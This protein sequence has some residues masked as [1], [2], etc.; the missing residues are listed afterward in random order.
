MQ[1]IDQSLLF[2]GKSVADKKLEPFNQVCVLLKQYLNS[3]RDKS[4]NLDIKKEIEKNASLAACELIA[5][6]TEAAKQCPSDGRGSAEEDPIYR[7]LNNLVDNM[8][9]LL[10]SIASANKSLKGEIVIRPT[11]Q[12]VAL[13]NHAL[14]CNYIHQFNFSH[15]VISNCIFNAHMADAE[16]DDAIIA[17]CTFGEDSAYYLA[18]LA[19]AREIDISSLLFESNIGHIDVKTFD[20]VAGE[21]DCSE[22]DDRAQKAYL[23]ALR[24]IRKLDIENERLQAEIKRAREEKSESSEASSK[25]FLRRSM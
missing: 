25:K 15:W 16:W 21:W 12:Y 2:F 10:D 13:V 20:E 6:I 9:V 5:Q 4:P 7:P 22:L 17:N 8:Y 18:D 1:S 19:K 3:I 24:D 11:L 14:N 23:S